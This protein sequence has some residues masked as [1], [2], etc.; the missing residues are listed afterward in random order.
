MQTRE[1]SPQPVSTPDD[2]RDGE[3]FTQYFE[4][5]AEPRREKSP[6]VDSGPSLRHVSAN[7]GVLTV[8]NEPH[9][10]SPLP[11][12]FS[13]TPP[14]SPRLRGPSPETVGGEIM[15]K[16]HMPPPVAHAD[17][18]PPSPQVHSPIRRLGPGGH[19]RQADE[20]HYS[21]RGIADTKRQ[22]T[23]TGE[24]PAQSVRTDRSGQKKLIV[25]G[26]A[27]HLIAT[28]H[29]MAEPFVERRSKPLRIEDT[30]D[31]ARLK[32]RGKVLE[33][34]ASGDPNKTTIK[35]DYD[36][37]LRHRDRQPQGRSRDE[38]Q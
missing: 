15:Q 33:A 36:D 5:D 7:A 8:E 30:S 25:R 3:D 2:L 27:L 20:D 38:G 6:E 26:K 22:R 24:N 10:A 4:R 35:N 21:Q 37:R 18:S 14:S 32:M 12:G 23:M 28:G 29:P 34:I 9:L 13:G 31:V 16:L 17:L 11:G 19:K 1:P